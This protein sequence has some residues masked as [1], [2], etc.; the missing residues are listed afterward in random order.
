MN[1]LNYMLSPNVP[2]IEIYGPNH[3]LMLFIL[4]VLIWL[5]VF[6]RQQINRH[7]AKICKILLVTL[8]IQ[9]TAE[10]LWYAV[11]TGFDPY[12]ALP[13]HISR[14]SSILQLVFLSLIVRS[15]SI[16][17]QVVEK[18][19][20]I[21]ANLIFFFS[22]FAYPTFFYPTEVYPIYHLQGV[23]FFINHLLTILIPIY[24]LLF[25]S[26]KPSFKA[27]NISFIYFTLYSICI[28]LINQR[29]GLNYFYT[30]QRIFSFLNEINP[31]LYFTLTLF[32]TYIAFNLMFLI[33]KTFY[34]SNSQVA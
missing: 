34:R 18:T 24:A 1:I 28:T 12:Q 23:S 3:L 15:F 8:I 5:I 10:Y 27:L 29:F 19:Y 7:S 22:I 33:Y 25:L 30:E 6:Y 17:T 9:Q 16:Q 4:L 2:F 14:V 26:S 32:L 20:P 31:Y 11:Y 21:L 13:L